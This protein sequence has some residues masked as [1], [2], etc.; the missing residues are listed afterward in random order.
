MEDNTTDSSKVTTYA[1]DL[2][3]SSYEWYRTHAIRSRRA[4]RISE[5]AVLI[6][7]AAIPA[8][9]AVAPHISIIPAVL[10]AVAVILS[11]L[12]AVFHWQDNYLRFSG[13]REAVEAERRL[14]YTGASPY[15]VSESKEQT[16][17]ASISQIEREE[18]GGWIK[19]A[20]ER[21]K[22]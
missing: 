19:I 3:N 4:Y 9:V 21:P 7:S 11:G 15:D 5:T 14:Y 20:A 6:V 1:M 17:A 22:P 2:A 8:S 13:A 12:R 10:G 18:M 16:L